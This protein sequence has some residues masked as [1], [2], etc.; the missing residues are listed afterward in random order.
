LTVDDIH[1]YYVQAADADVLVHNCNYGKRYPQI[2]DALGY[3]VRE[4]RDALHLVKKNAPMGGGPR[5]NPDVLVDLDSG[6]VFIEI[7]K[8]KPGDDAI[9]NIF[10]HLPGTA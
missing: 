1:T 10:E 4:V 7:A 2:A 5:N 6:D 8:N 3:S 9:G